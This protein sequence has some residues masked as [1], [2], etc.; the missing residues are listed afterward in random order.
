MSPLVFDPLFKRIRWGGRR[1]G[2][3]LHKPIGPEADYAESWEIADHGSDQSVVRGGDFAGQTLAQLVERQNLPLLGR[4]TGREQFP[5]LVKFLDASDVL[6]V[7]VH[8][9]DL[10]AKE[11]APAENGK[12]EA[13]VVLDAE[14]GSELFVGLKAGVTPEELRTALE[15]GTVESLLHRFS[16]NVG[17]CIFVPAGTVHAIGAGV[18]LAEIQQSSDLTFRMHDWGR[19]GADGKP[20]E[21]HIDSALRATDFRRGPVDLV[22]PRI[23]ESDHHQEELVCSD[24]FVLH[25][26]RG[27]APFSLP[28][29]NAFH[30]MMVLAGHARLTSDGESI[31][32]PLGKTVLLPAERGDTVITPAADLVLL[33]AFL[34]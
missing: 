9:D 25:R 28:D 33:D 5:L 17:D 30:V 11:F 2:S 31:E 32:M 19:M 23:L 10:L 3:V 16:A 15:A 27:E 22:T 24:H 6:S 8:P 13:W 29:D 21:L 4:H 7:Q 18:L 1:L 34:P 26:H 12:T 20:R 14:P